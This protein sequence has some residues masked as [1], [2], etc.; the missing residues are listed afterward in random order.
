MQDHRKLKEQLI[1]E[2]IDVERKQRSSPVDRVRMFQFSSN[3]SM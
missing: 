2:T 1:E 3:Q